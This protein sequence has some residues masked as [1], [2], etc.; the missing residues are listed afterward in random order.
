QSTE[1]MASSAGHD[2]ESLQLRR[3]TLV[4]DVRGWAF[5]TIARSLQARL[6]PL[7]EACT[8]VYWEDFDDPNALVRHVNRQKPDLVHFFFREHLDLILKTV[9]GQSEAFFTFC[10]YA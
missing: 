1:L 3:L 2:A 10:R 8:I 6:A 9:A 7:M 4:V 5:D